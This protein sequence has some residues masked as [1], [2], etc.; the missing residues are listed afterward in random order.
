M[1]RDESTHKI[2]GYVT[3]DEFYAGLNEAK[4]EN[5]YV[6]E[7][8]WVDIGALLAGMWQAFGEGRM[9]VV[10]R[11]GFKRPEKKEEIKPEIKGTTADIMPIGLKVKI[12]DPTTSRDQMEGIIKVIYKAGELDKEEI[13]EIDFGN[14]QLGQFKHTSFSIVAETPKRR[15]SRAKTKKEEVTEPATE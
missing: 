3:E 15:P 12:S 8:G 14:G 4:K 10:P 6:D 9:A 2:Y 7:K 13:Y 11:E 1:N 5:L